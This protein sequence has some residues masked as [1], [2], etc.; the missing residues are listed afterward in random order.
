MLNYPPELN[1]NV[2][3]LLR[4]FTPELNSNILDFSFTSIKEVLKGFVHGC[5]S[6]Y[7]NFVVY[8]L[9]CIHNKYLSNSFKIDMNVLFAKI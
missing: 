3:Q 4:R 8:N 5:F 9:S 2:L 7:N 6:L 1:T